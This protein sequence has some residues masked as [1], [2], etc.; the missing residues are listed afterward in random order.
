[1]KCHPTLK[2]FVKPFAELRITFVHGLFLIFQ[3]GNCTRK[4]N[5][6][7]GVLNGIILVTSSWF[8]CNS[9][10]T[11]LCFTHL[12]SNSD[13]L[14]QAFWPIIKEPPFSKNPDIP[15]FLQ[16]SGN[17]PVLHWRPY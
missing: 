11:S 12:L 13:K 6:V 3:S 14:L 10:L 7:S 9:V 2:S 8:L 1:M 16:L 5:V 4:R 15:C 17:P